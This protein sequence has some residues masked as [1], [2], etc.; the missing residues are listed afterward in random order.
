[1]PKK[2]KKT[3]KPA[4]TSK[5]VRVPVDASLKKRYD[6]LKAEVDR[7]R[8]AGDREWD[9]LWEAVGEIIEHEPAL[10]AVGGFKNDREF[11]AEVVGEPAVRTAYRNIKVAKFASPREET[12]YGV[13]KLDAALSYIEA[14]LGAPLEHPPLPI[15]FDRL[16]FGPERKTLENARREDVEA[17]T[18]ALTKKAKKPT[19]SD[20]R[21]AVELFARHPALKGVRVRVRRGIVSFTGVPAASMGAFVKAVASMDWGKAPG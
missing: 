3:K 5:D 9:R 18:R 2:I 19:S 1:M 16:R 15:A 21:A 4:L 14:K 11:F 17:A 12:L 7:A 20:E 13:S 10:Y 6:A 8:A